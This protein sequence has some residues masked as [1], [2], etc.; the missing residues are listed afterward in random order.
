M[1][2]VV[3]DRYGP[4]DVLR[5]EEV[6]TPTPAA[7]EVLVE[8]HSAAVNSW[9]WE[10]LSGTFLT[11]FFGAPRR[12]RY[13]ILGADI[14]GR[15]VETGSGASRFKPGD[16]IY[17][18]ISGSGWGGFA[19]YVCAR[20]EVLAIRPPS[21]T[22]AEAAAVPQ[23]GVLAFQGFRKAGEIK[24][25]E[26]VLV[27]GGGGG[28]GSFA[29]QLAKAAG[30]E[31]TG[32]DNV[33]KLD[34]MRSLGADHVIDFAQEDFTKSGRQYDVIHD[35]AAYHSAF[36]CRRVLKP[37]GRYVTTGGSTGRLL[38]V[39]LVG[40]GLSKFGDKRMGVLVHRP[41]AQD[42]DALRELLEEGGLAP[43]VDECF[44][45]EETADAFRYFSS[46]RF[47]GKLVV[48]IDHTA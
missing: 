13:R 16:E 8:V 15:V 42:L 6:P 17:G 29:I 45:L 46:G 48:T 26:Q 5:L 35:N 2:A 36:D 22:F 28:V 1:K 19:E 4:P 44:P 38:Q 25:G 43:A 32:V 34:A 14:A 12:P 9:D 41:S 3:Y 10:L 27:N 33:H 23:A 30:A 39:A 47:H 7:D 21:L 20:E 37:E 40:L 11:R 31:V 24:S 18:D